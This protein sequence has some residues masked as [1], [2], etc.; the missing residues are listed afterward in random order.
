MDETQ[1]QRW[2]GLHLRV[3]RGELLASEEQAYYETIMRQLDGNEPL[4]PLR[5][6]LD[7]RTKLRQLEAERIRLEEQRSRLDVEIVDLESQL[8]QR[9]REL[10]G[11]KS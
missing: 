11:A 9:A 1:R 6:A 3:A 8:G 4:E 5:S 7:T 10:L 2:W